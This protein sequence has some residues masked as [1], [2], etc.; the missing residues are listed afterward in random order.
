MKIETIV[1]TGGIGSGKSSV[2]ESIKRSSEVKVGFFNFD[3]YTRELY[4]REDV[5][6][7]LKTMFGTSDKKEISDIVFNQSRQLGKT[8]TTKILL[9]EL[10][11]FFFKLVEDK[12]IELVNRK[13]VNTMVIEM[14][15]F[16]EMKK[17]STKMQ[18]VRT[19]VKVI[20]VAADDEVRVQRVKNR[21]GFTEEKVRDIMSTQVPQQYKIENADYVI[22]N[23]HGH[24]DVH[25]TDLMKHK[26]RKVFFHVAD[27]RQDSKVSA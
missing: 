4:E 2:I 20:V 3:D 8:E 14:P 17:L 25:V 12:F 10:N 5:K 19:K 11:Q 7:F 6:Q 22:D 13:P 21:D 18:L 27:Q 9:D 1:I 24:C 23:T 16:F 26:F 15:M